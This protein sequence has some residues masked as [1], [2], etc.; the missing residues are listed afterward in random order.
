MNEDAAHNAQ[1]LGLILGDHPLGHRI[2]HR[3]G[4]RGLSRSEHLHRLLGTLDRD[5]G[6][7]HRRR[8]HR[9][10]GGQHRQQVAVTL[11]LTRQGVGKRD[12]YRT[13]FAADQ[14]INVSDLITIAHQ[15]LSNIHRHDKLLFFNASK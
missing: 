1:V 15:G 11:A 4:D 8:F 7:Q 9:Q 12:P 13:V 5:L 10:V 6:D 3:L 14:Q 2:G